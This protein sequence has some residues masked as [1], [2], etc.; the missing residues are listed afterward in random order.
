[1]P[2]KRKIPSKIPS[3]IPP[4]LSSDDEDC[5]SHSEDGN[6]SGSEV[7]NDN[8]DDSEDKDES[9]DESDN[10][11]TVGSSD[12]KSDGGDDNGSDGS[13]VEGSE[14]EEGPATK[15]ARRT[16]TRTSVVK[17]VE[18]KSKTITSG[19]KA[20]KEKSAKKSAS[21]KVKK[22]S[23]EIKISKP[24]SLKKSDR[25]EEARKAYKWWEAPKLSKGMNW[26]YLEHPGV[27]FQS[28][29]VP[30]NIPLSY[31][32]KELKLTPS[33][34]EVATFYAAMPEDGPQLGNPK[35]RKVF[36]QN[37]FEDFKEVLGPSHII[38]SFDKCDFSLIR[39]HLALQKNLRKV[40]TDEEKLLKKDEKEKALLKYGYALIDGRIEKVGI[41]SFSQPKIAYNKTNIRWEILTWNLRD[42]LGVVVNIRKQGN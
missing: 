34:E 24:K 14:E 42:Y 38:K 2:P 11:G 18:K 7:S 29:Y 28:P 36:Q 33:E 13:S 26:Q 31:D 4:K 12:T 3:K 35:S 8:E 41:L 10:E 27:A 6:D 40:E 5:L 21:I 25:I 30:H 1:M 37:F 15:R 32:G 17:K 19:K 23:A 22:A 16:S 20:S 39:E 9:D